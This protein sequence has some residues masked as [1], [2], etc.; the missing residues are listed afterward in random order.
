MAHKAG[1]AFR[2]CDP[3]PILK[4]RIVPDVLVVAA[5][6]FGDPIAALI[7]M[8]TDDGSQHVTASRQADREP[9]SDRDAS[10]AQPAE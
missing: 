5:F 6:Q 4:R 8:E 9:D 10:P 2:G 1:A 3:G 7:L